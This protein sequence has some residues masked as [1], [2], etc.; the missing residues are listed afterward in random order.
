MGD[1]APKQDVGQRG[2]GTVHLEF[3][4]VPEKEGWAELS[5]A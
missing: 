2:A 4:L 3:K 5:R 1:M